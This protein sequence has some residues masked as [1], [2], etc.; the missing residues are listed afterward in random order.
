MIDGYVSGNGRGRALVEVEYTTRIERIRNAT[1]G[2]RREE[3]TVKKGSSTNKG[4]RG[5]YCKWSR[6]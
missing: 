5:G 2:Q 6:K 4:M 1:R 3:V